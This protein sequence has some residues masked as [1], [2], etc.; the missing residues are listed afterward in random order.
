MTRIW[1][2]G[3]FDL[4]HYGHG[5]AVRQ[6]KEFGQELYAGVHSDEAITLNKGPPVMTLA[7]RA[8]L[9]SA[10]RWVDCVVQDAPYVTEI[11]FVK[12]HGIDFV[13][14]GDDVSTDAD[15]LDTYR[16]VKQ[17]GM[18]KEC[19][20]TQGVSTT[21]AISRIL[22]GNSNETP[23][24]NALTRV[25]AKLLQAFATTSPAEQGIAAYLPHQCA[26]TTLGEALQ[27][28]REEID[29]LQIGATRLPTPDETITCLCSSWDLFCAQ[30]VEQLASLRPSYTILGIWSAEVTKRETGSYPVLSLQ[31]RALGALQCKY[32][33]AVV[34]SLDHL[35]PPSW[36]GVEPQAIK[37]SG[38]SG[39]VASSAR[40]L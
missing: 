3:C 2:D 24:V 1:V 13:V 39:N 21:D 5:N 9:L 30:D 27:Q 33:D 20:R 36:L 23:D 6:A 37:P 10:C 19:K 25:D 4:F 40:A 38:I 8:C 14:H 15:G 31:E 32:V 34:I 12:Q 7:E 28:S 11:P 29:A 17:A 35:S 22:Q 16:F 26:Q 18:Y